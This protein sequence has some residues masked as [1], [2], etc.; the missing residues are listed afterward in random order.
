M[1]H[2]KIKNNDNNS[3]Y[4]TIQNFYILLSLVPILIL[5]HSV[6]KNSFNIPYWDD[7]DAILNFL[8]KWVD[9]SPM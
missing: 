5:F 4:R 7:Y 9:L 8:N 1:K 6:Y 3:N 2:Y